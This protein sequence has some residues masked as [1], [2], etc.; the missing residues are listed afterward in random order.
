MPSND[1]IRATLLQVIDEQRPRDQTTNLQ[2][3]GVLRAVAERL[4]FRRDLPAEQALLTQ[5]HELFRTGFL[6]WG[7][8]LNNSNAPFFHITEQGNH[9]LANQSRDPGNPDGYLKLVQELGPISPIAWSYLEEAVRCYVAGLYK[10]AS[11]MTGG[12]A[13]SI[14]L[15]LRDETVGKLE[16][17][18]RA[19]HRDLSDWRIKRVLDALKSHFDGVKNQLPLRLREEFE[20]YWPAFTQQIRASRNEAGHPSSVAPVTPQTVHASLLIFPELVRLSNELRRWVSE[21]MA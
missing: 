6:A 7:L 4:G 1:E 15:E 17:L 11:V 5:F 16:G 13:E 14:A 20:A 3:G 18:G 19:P 10:A 8:D 21:E 9:T 12:A 2:S